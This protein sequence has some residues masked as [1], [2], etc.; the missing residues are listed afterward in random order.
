MIEQ[1]GFCHHNQKLLSLLNAKLSYLKA[2][3][4]QVT[5]RT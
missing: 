4:E 2:L 3:I 5:F 1:S